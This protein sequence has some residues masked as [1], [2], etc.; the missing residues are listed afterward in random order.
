LESN[1]T[2]KFSP[3]DFVL[4]VAYKL[5][6]PGRVI[7]CGLQPGGLKTYEIEYAID[8]SVHKRLFYEDEITDI[9]IREV[10]IK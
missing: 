8:N 3:L 2:Y 10:G 4:V 7:G 5:N 6:V 1:I 9:P